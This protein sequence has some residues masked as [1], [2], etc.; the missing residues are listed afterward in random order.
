MFESRPILI[1]F[2][3]LTLSCNIPSNMIL[4]PSSTLHGGHFVSCNHSGE[5]LYR[6]KSFGPLTSYVPASCDSGQA[7][8]LA[9]PNTP[10][11]G[12]GCVLDHSACFTASLPFFVQKLVSF[13]DFEKYP[14]SS[15]SAVK[16]GDA[17]GTALKLL[18]ANGTW[19]G[20][21]VYDEP[22][23]FGYD[24][25]QRECA[26]MAGGTVFVSFWYVAVGS[27]LTV[28]LTAGVAACLM[29]CLDSKS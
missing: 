4:L 14:N 16:C 7:V 23:E 6:K 15:L 17:G 11:S 19:L 20:Q 29:Y 27:I 26:K 5:M 13:P 21:N 3:I 28:M 24:F 12:F 1:T 22:K 8:E 9:P 25:F 10:I 2:F 18:C